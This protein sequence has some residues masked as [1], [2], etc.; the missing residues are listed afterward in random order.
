[1]NR[2]KR[3]LAKAREKAEYA[4]ANLRAWKSGRKIVVFESDDWGGVRMP[5]PET[6]RRLQE[7]GLRVDTSSFNRLDGLE[8]RTDLENLLEVLQK[9]H[10]AQGKSPRFTCNMVLGNPDFDAIERTQFRQFVRESMFDS[11]M[12]YHREDL[13][14]AWE[15]AIAE[16]LL[17]PQFHC[18][19]HV[20][21]ILWMKDLR[22]GNVETK[23]C[24]QHNFF[25]LRTKTGSKIQKHYLAA[26]SAE[27]S[28]ELDEI[29]K[30]AHDGLKQFQTMFGFP[31]QTFVACNYVLP[32]ELEETLAEAGVKGIQTRIKQ[33]IPVLER[34]GQR[35]HRRRFT[36]QRNRWEQYYTV[37]NAVFEPYQNQ[38]YD[39]AESAL[40]EIQL[41]FQFKTPAIISTHRINYT[42]AMDVGH[43]DRSLKS[44]D[45]LLAAIVTRW[46]DVEFLSSDDLIRFISK[47][48][49]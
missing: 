13:R 8:R 30:V 45:R 19:E 24:F 32:L 49:P 20:N 26:Y 41:A 3:Q 1:M 4:F 2:I 44:L 11:Y 38:T 40:R 15:Q 10:N 36:G 35:I 42:S 25:G 18:R 9:H 6:L 17:Q 7:A 16:G 12:R 48:L 21:Q 27:N 34:N 29:K 31:S 33:T 22:D 28:Q 46:P 47:Q 43:R 5:G 37:R 39:W 23:L 14:A